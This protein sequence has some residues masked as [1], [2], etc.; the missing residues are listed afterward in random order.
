M[1]QAR[2]CPSRSNR[3]LNGRSTATRLTGLRDSVL[4]SEGTWFPPC[5]WEGLGEGAKLDAKYFSGTRRVYPP[6]YGIKGGSR[7]GPHPNPLPMEREKRL[8]TLITLGAVLGH[9]KSD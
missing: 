8:S 1:S 4:V 3:I 9:M 6:Q 7:S 5:L 2:A